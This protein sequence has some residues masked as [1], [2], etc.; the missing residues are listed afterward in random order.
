MLMPKKYLR[1]LLSILIII[2]CH[3]LFSQTG[4]EVIKQFVIKYKGVKAAKFNINKTERI[5][6]Q[7]KTSTS[8]FKFERVPFK[9]YLKR[10]SPDPGLE[11]IF[12][13]NEN[14][15]KVL[16]NPNKFPWITLSLDPYS[17]EL[18]KTEHHTIYE[19]GFDY[20]NY[21]LEYLFE[22]YDSELDEMVKN[23]GI[24]NWNGSNCFY[25][26]LTNNHFKL[27]NYT[28]SKGENLFNIAKKR[29][30]NEYMILE[31]NPQIKNYYDVKPGDIIKVPNDYAQKFILYIDKKTYMPL[32]IKVYDN[33][34]LFEQYDYNN[35]ILNPTFTPNDFSK[36]NKE[37]HFL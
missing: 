30:V 28:V 36:D 33:I 5:K 17:S 1:I 16:V 26:T 12:V 34:G 18:T 20:F 22:K 37:Y 23:V 29:N 14:N 7:L 19:A 10:I 15:N 31:N 13:K 35:L 4:A 3:L 2:N 21:L 24:I 6:G 25:I 8:F 9:V 27:E 32:L 11:V